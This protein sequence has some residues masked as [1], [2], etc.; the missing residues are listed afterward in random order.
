MP[1]AI[2]PQ[3]LWNLRRVGQP[4]HIPGST[5]VVVPVL[6]FDE[7]NESHSVLYIVDRQGATT[8]LTSTQRHAS[9]P[10]PSP[11]GTR[12]AFLA[13]SGHDDRQVHVMALDGGEAHS[14]TD[15]PLGC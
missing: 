11:D 1:R 9:A 3:D 10:A 15:L 12:V 5:K 8:R 14:V 13:K 7:E 2:T 6:T 4:E